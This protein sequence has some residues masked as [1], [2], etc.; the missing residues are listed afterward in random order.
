MSIS[1][2]HARAVAA[3][4]LFGST[5][6]GAHA[7]GTYTAAQAAA[8]A[9]S[10]GENC[11]R[12]HGARLQGVS[13]PA[14]K[15]GAS[16]IKGDTLADTYTFLSAQ[17]PADAPGSLSQTDYVN[18]TAFILSKNGFKAGTTKL[19]KASARSGKKIVF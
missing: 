17:M 4:L 2:G 11:S 14:L 8:G 5:L 12:C 9:K 16:G 15:G 1:T 18:I 19:T 6:S 10:F 13:A 3:V 7:A